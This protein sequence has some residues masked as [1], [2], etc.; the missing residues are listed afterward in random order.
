MTSNPS[1]SPDGK[2][3]FYTVCN[4]NL[5]SDIA[6]NIHY[7]TRM[8]DGSYSNSTALSSNINSTG[9]TTTQPSVRMDEDLMFLYFV[10]DRPGGEGGLDIWMSNFDENMVFSTPVNTGI[11]TE[12][13]D[14]TPYYHHN[15]KTL[16]F[17]SNGRDGF[18]GFDLYKNIGESVTN[19]GA[20]YNTSYNDIYFFLNESGDKGYLSSNR[21]GSS[22]T[23]E[24]YETCCYDIYEVDLNKQQIN[25]LAL[26]YDG[27]SGEELDNSRVV[28]K[29]L[30][31]GDII[32]DST[33]PDGNDHMV[34]LDCDAK[35]ELTVERDGYQTVTKNIGDFLANCGD[36]KVEEKINMYKDAIKLTVFTFDKTTQ[37]PLDF[38]SVKLICQTT[39]QEALRQTGGSNSVIFN[40]GPDCTQ[41][42]LIGTKIGYESGMLDF[43]SA[44]LSGDV[45][46]DLFLTEQ[47]IA[48]IEGMIPLSLYFDNDHPNPNSEAKTTNL[49]YSETYDKY[50]P[51]KQEFID[52]Y[53]KQKGES[54]KAEVRN[55]FENE[56]KRG[57]DN[58][59]LM[60]STLL[61]VMK[62]G[63]RVN[64]Y[65]RGF[66]SPL[67][68]SDYNLALGQRRVHSVQNAIKKWDGGALMK[69]INAGQLIIT[70]RS[71]G[72]TSAPTGISDIQSDSANSIYSPRASRERR[73]EIDEIK[74]N[75]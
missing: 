27:T 49:W 28:L 50:Y 70:E 65:L 31:T 36:G 71:F 10:S 29:N 73:V 62:S 7:A 8:D 40:I 39:G 12:L 9:Y 59:E 61:E 41:Y 11:N 32:Y 67:A 21:L 74:F 26:V 64:L 48:T 2:L 58:L 56:V 55:F 13:D 5:Q 30:E 42:K 53:G 1:F 63:Q 16:Y 35:Y 44:G 45:S 33:N 47:K 57:N 25:L 52:E 18:G 6:C 46:K 3:M 38:T 66:A 4:Y 24:T 54:G 72:E 68:K 69:Y 17:S 22:F 20:T 15:S 43:S 34:D 75:N 14:I 60:L 23:D 19:L 51:R 37:L